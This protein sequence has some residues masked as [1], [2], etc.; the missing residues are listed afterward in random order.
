MP[1][2][3]AGNIQKSVVTGSPYSPA[4]SFNP[5]KK[6]FFDTHPT[7]LG[8]LSG[9]AVT[10][11]GVNVTVPAQTVFIQ[12]GIVVKLTSPFQVAIPGGGYPKYVVA[13]NVNENAGG[14]VTIEI[15]SS[16][17]APQVLLATLTNS[18]TV[19]LPKQIS[20]RALR[21]DLDTL[22][23]TSGL[24]DVEQ[25]G[26]LVKANIDEL[27]AI[28]PNV[29]IT[30]GGGTQADIG[31]KLDIKEA[32][33]PKTVRTEE[34][35]FTGAVTVTPN[36][37]NKATV[38]IGAMTVK[39]EGITLSPTKNK[40]NF[41]GKGVTATTDGV[42]SSQANVDIPGV[43]G[44]L[45]GGIIDGIVDGH[46]SV[47][48][49]VITG[50]VINIDGVRSSPITT[51]VAIA[52]NGS[53]Q[54]R[55]DMLQWNGTTLTVKQGT[56]GADAPSPSPDPGNIPIALALVPNAAPALLQSMNKQS[57]ISNAVIVAYYYSN[58]GLH[59]SRVG[60]TPDPTIGTTS[61]K[62]AEEMTLSV[63][64]PRSGYRYELA[65][66]TMIAQ[67]LYGFLNEG[68]LINMSFDGADEDDLVHHRGY[69][70]NNLLGGVSIHGFEIGMAMFYNRFVLLGP[71]TM[72]GRVKQGTLST[73]E[74]LSKMRRRIWIHEIQ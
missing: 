55:T 7:T 26:S 27:N 8:V 63:Y 6:L 18:T 50:L 71:H 37:A 46:A 1:I 9:G 70:H 49:F 56:P 74:V 23:A 39:D 38:A 54:P 42:D 2:V 34:I 52:A 28:G 72:K 5:D 35:D 73:P 13:D 40:V 24:L 36:T 25:D 21:Q 68:A 53:G 30:D 59:A 16:V 22:A 67:N 32:G 19:V 65:W 20:I 58:G 48:Q 57:S 31:V 11:D 15:F 10:A 51:T 60:V 44:F 4:V 47:R 17:L 33:T 66:D 29:Q 41:T 14:P 3:P 61:Y 45:E 69:M 62:D 64:F 43:E 12:N